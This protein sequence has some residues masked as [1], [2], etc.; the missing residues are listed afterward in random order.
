MGL[1]LTLGPILYKTVETFLKI[2]IAI[3]VPTIFFLSIILAKWTD[4]AA[5][6]RG[7]VGIGDGYLF[8]PEGIAIASFLAAFAYSGAGG[9]LNLAQAFYIRDKALCCRSGGN[10]SNIRQFYSSF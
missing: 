7:V 4:W 6:A 3:A 9:N 5:L 1:I 8:L 10:I 2:L